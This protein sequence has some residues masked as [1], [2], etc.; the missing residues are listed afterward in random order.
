MAPRARLVRRAVSRDIRDGLLQDMVAMGIMTQALRA[1]L[2]GDEEG[3]Q[4]RL[5]D[6]LSDTLATGA[7]RLRLVINE[8]E[9]DDVA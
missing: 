9:F 2:Q 1:R 4:L 3:D 7:E 5:L 8:L 6:T